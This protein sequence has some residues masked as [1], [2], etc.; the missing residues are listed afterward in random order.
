[1]STQQ[2]DRLLGLAQRPVW[3]QYFI[4]YCS[5]LKPGLHCVNT[6]SCNSLLFVE[7]EFLNDF[8]DERPQVL[9]IVCP[10]PN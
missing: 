2:S 4:F 8:Y 9:T 10:G 1:M 7:G 6:W 5:P 3:L